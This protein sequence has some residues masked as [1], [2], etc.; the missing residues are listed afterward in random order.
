MLIDVVIECGSWI[1][2][3]YRNRTMLVRKIVGEVGRVVYERRQTAT[4]S[5]SLVV[6]AL[7][8]HCGNFAGMKINNL[9][10][11]QVVHSSCVH[12]VRTVEILLE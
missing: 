4:S 6:C 8:S 12:L 11:H 2:V 1:V 3:R 5:R 10:R 9:L 7:G